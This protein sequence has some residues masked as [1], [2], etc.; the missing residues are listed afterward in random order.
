MHTWIGEVCVFQQRGDKPLS[1]SPG[2]ISKSVTINWVEIQHDDLSLPS[3]Q[4]LGDNR[5]AILWIFLLK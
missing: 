2:V 1:D 3:H 4:T 5:A